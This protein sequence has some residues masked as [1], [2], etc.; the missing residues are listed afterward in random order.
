MLLLVAMLSVGCATPYQQM[1]RMGGYADAQLAARVFEI[2]FVG[3]G[4]TRRTTVE[5]YAMRR[6]AEVTVSHG[7]AG[8][9]EMQSNGGTDQS[10]MYVNDQAQVVSKHS[11]TKRI[12]LL[13]AQEMGQVPAALDARLILARPA[14]ADED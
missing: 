8:F 2:R 5:A 13:T 6:A 12:Y 3:N 4:Y 14:E 9:V 1:D 11:M 7:F 10:L